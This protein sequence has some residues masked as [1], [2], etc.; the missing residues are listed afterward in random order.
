MASSG[1]GSSWDTKLANGSNALRTSS[2]F[3]DTLVGVGDNE[4]SFPS[5]N[6]LENSCKYTKNEKGIC[7]FVLSK[8]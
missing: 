5:T 3:C 6:L 2:P 7:P 1:L 4:N 8:L